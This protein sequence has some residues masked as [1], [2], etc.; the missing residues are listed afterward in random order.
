MPPQSP[1]PTPSAARPTTVSTV[2]VKLPQ[3]WAANPR[4]WFVQAEASFRRH[5]VTA[6]QTK[7]DHLLT[8]LPETVI[9]RVMDLVESMGDGAFQPYEALKDRLVGK[10]T[11]SRWARINKLID[12]PDIG[13]RRPSDLMDEMLALLPPQETP[14]D[15]FLGMFLRRLPVHMREKLGSSEF[16]GAREMAELADQMWDARGGE[17]ATMSAS[18]TAAVS[19]RQPSRS[20]SPGR[21]RRTS[22]DHKGATG[23]SQTPAAVAGHCFYHERFGVKAHQCEPPCTWKPASGNG[24]GR[25]RN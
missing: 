3:F 9:V 25:R 19:N 14:G 23:R 6:S 24:R 16:E 4:A 22:P 11:M 17:A 13:D 18:I 10:F 8:A 20:P 12:L 5:S 7:Y 1:T 15:L 21:R 2:T